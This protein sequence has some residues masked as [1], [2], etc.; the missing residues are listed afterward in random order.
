MKMRRKDLEELG[1]TKEQVDAIMKAHGE[2]INTIKAEREQLEQERNKL[3]A[4]LEKV[5]SEKSQ[6]EEE[7]NSFK[8]SKMT[9]EEKR[10]ALLKK[11]QEE[12]EKI[13][14]EAKEA[15]AKYDR[16]YKETKVKGVLLS[17]GLQEEVANK[18]VARLL[19]ETEEE[20]I[21]NATEF[22]DL[23]EAQ[24]KEAATKAVEEAL[25]GTPTPKQK[26]DGG[27]Q[28]PYIPPRVF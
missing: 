6:L 24:R 26:Q 12:Q 16:L 19:G 8:N 18:F 7:Y 20:S 23:L 25:K 5:V 11:Q 1:L 13:L 2:D 9:E 22:A 21:K 10:Q 14:K 28:Q 4:D 27:E 3:K 17:K 15:Q